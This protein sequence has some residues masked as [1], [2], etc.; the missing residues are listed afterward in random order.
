MSSR[1]GSHAFLVAMSLITVFIFSGTVFGWGA[2]SA[3]LL[4]EGYYDFK[5]P[6]PDPQAPCDEQLQ[7]LNNAFTVASTF[8]SLAAFANGW[9]VDTFGPTKSTILAGILSVVGYLGIA[10]TR[11]GTYTRDLASHGGF[12][13]FLWSTSLVALG[14]SLTMFIGYQA[15]FI[16]PSHFTLLIEINSCLFDAGTI[17]F[18]LLKV[19]YDLGVPFPLFFWSY[20]ALAGVCFLLFAVAWAM[21]EEELNTLRAAQGGGGGDARPE[22]ERPLDQ[23][24]LLSQLKTFEFAAIFIYSV[25]QVPRANMYMG[26]VNL[27]NSKIAE[28]SASA[29]SLGW[30][31]TLTGFIIPFGFL[32]VPLIEMSIHKKGCMFTIQLTTVMGIAFNAMQFAPNLYVQLGTVTIFAAWRAFLYSVIS[33]FNGETFGVVTMGRVMGLCFF[34]SGLSN[35]A[36]GP[37]V[38]SAVADNDFSILLLL[39]VLVCVPLPLIFFFLS[40]KQ[41]RESARGLVSSSRTATHHDPFGAMSMTRARSRNWQRFEE[42]DTTNVG[43]SLVR[44]STI[45]GE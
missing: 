44:L 14:G 6:T 42:G 10:L 31:E 43:S 5:C 24:S 19:L 11:A 28:E 25:I 2:F 16:V 37:L 36:T 27:I 30:I 9:L 21:N 20:T 40:L 4:K 38:N 39:D 7:A 32:V 3:M 34:F 35:V 29:G 41:R 12:D 8:V 15:P 45:M 22:H 23:R 13:V 17:I 26:T 33:A 18:P 1:G